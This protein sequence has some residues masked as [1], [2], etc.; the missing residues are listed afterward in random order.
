MKELFYL[1][2]YNNIEDLEKIQ[3]LTRLAN[4]RRDH[5]ELHFD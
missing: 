4:E 3:F 5:F 2:E 1:N